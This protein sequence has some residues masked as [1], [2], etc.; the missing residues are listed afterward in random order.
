LLYNVHISY[1]YL[2]LGDLS[3]GEARDG[4]ERRGAPDRSKHR[5]AAGA[6]ETLASGRLTQ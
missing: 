4:N 6:F 3:F 2:S 5:Q 1:R